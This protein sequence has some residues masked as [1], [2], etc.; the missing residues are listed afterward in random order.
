MLAIPGSLRI[1]Q[2]AISP[3]G[4]IAGDPSGMTNKL[5]H[6]EKG[7]AAVHQVRDAGMEAAALGFGQGRVTTRLNLGCQ[8][9]ASLIHAVGEDLA[10]HLQV[11]SELPIKLRVGALQ[12]SPNLLQIPMRRR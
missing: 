5:L 9:E 4:F 11:E 7:G 2:E 6:G 1:A 12:L 3:K 10:E 8:M